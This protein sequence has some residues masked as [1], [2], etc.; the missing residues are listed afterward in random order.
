MLNSC[1]DPLAYTQEIAVYF[2]KCRASQLRC[3][4]A[5]RH[6]DITALIIGNPNTQAFIQQW[7]LHQFLNEEHSVT[8]ILSPS[9]RSFRVD[10]MCFRSVAS[11]LGFFLLGLLQ[12]G[13]VSSGEAE[14]L[15]SGEWGYVGIMH[16]LWR[17]FFLMIS[18]VIGL[19]FPCFCTESGRWGIYSCQQ[20]SLQVSQQG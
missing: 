13:W 7:K 1:S 19:T 9:L 17:G 14:R 18:F 2:A 3:A 6:N 11:S 4:P 5:Y 8:L 15:L 16:L 10:G 12:K 20:R